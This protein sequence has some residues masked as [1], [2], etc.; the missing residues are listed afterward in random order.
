LPLRISVSYWSAESEQNYKE[1]QSELTFK[2]VRD[3]S[4]LVDLS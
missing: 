2:K 1:F 4:I 3:Y